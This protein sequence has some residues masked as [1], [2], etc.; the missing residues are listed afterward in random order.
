MTSAQLLSDTRPTQ[1]IYATLLQWFVPLG[2]GA[3]RPSGPLAYA[4]TNHK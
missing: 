4:A 1:T 3:T 2:W